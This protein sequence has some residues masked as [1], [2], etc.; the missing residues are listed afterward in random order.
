MRLISYRLLKIHWNTAKRRK[1]SKGGHDHLQWEDVSYLDRSLNL[2]GFCW[3]IL[4]DLN[5]INWRYQCWIEFTDCIYCGIIRTLSGSIF[6]IPTH[7][8]SCI[9][10]NHQIKC[11]ISSL[12]IK[13]IHEILWKS[14]Y[15]QKL[16]PKIGNDSTV[17][18][19]L[20]W[21]WFYERCENMVI[22]IGYIKEDCK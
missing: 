6:L 20:L 17:S 13:K 14:I 18:V 7:Q 9:Y 22:W 16:A 12:I 8:K 21:L 5:D 15:P 19:K 4:L 3:Y 1:I 2:C 10:N 11:K